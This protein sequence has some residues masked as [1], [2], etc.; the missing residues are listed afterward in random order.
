[1]NAKEVEK[2]C[3]GLRL[4]IED[5]DEV[6]EIFQRADKPLELDTCQTTGNTFVK[7]ENNR[8]EESYRSPWSNQYQPAVTDATFPNE[9]LRALEVATNTMLAEYKKLYFGAAAASSAYCS[10]IDGQNFILTICIVKSLTVI[11]NVE[12]AT[13]ETMHLAH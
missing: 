10:E 4:L 5:D 7:C 11:G 3:M 13:W 2:C 8:D 12:K 6:S 1:M 9:D